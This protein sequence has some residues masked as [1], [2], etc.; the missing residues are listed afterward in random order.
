[1][2]S[3]CTG[4]RGTF[5]ICRDVQIIDVGGGGLVVFAI[6]CAVYGSSVTV[7]DSILFTGV[8]VTCVST[9]CCKL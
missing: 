1:M 8:L 5:L 6:D 9:L 2:F 3:F 4:N 7:R